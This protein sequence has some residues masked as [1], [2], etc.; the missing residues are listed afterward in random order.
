MGKGLNYL[1][2]SP[3]EAK[4]TFNID[5]GIPRFIRNKECSFARVAKSV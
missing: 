4:Q 2:K 3:H 5:S 1:L